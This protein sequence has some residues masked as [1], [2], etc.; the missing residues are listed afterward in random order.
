VLATGLAL[1]MA[2]LPH[3]PLLPGNP[4]DKVVHA[5]TF[6]VLSLLISLGWP[7]TGLWRL[8]LLLAA[9]GGLIELAQG[10]SVIGRDA[11]TYDWLTDI[12]AAAML[13][14]VWLARRLWIGEA[15]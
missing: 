4:G 13:A 9:F 2:L 10:T 12:A 15:R 1:V 3:P 6:V 5:V 14:A 11:S 8:L 7:R